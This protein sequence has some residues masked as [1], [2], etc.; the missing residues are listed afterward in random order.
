MFGFGGTQWAAQA[1][2]V[3]MKINK[4]VKQK[5]FF[6]FVNESSV[7]LN[8]T[9]FAF[10]PFRPN[11]DSVRQ[12]VNRYVTTTKRSIP[13]SWMQANPTSS[14]RSQNMDRR[15]FPITTRKPSEATTINS[16]WNEWSPLKPTNLGENE[17]DKHSA[18]AHDGAHFHGSNDIIRQ[19]TTT[20]PDMAPWM[21]EILNEY[22]S[23]TTPRSYANVVDEM[24]SWM[25]DVLNE[26]STTTTRKNIRFDNNNPNSIIFG[27]RGTNGNTSG[28]VSK[29]NGDLHMPKQNRYTTWIMRIEAKMCLIDLFITVCKYIVVFVK[30]PKKCHCHSLVTILTIR[31]FV[32]ES[33]V[34]FLP[35]SDDNESTTINRRPSEHNSVDPL[36]NRSGRGRK[37][38][39]GNSIGLLA[40]PN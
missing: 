19:A 38:E 16:F 22:T 18:H 12:V 3:E 23:T 15:F 28:G 11:T 26:Y 27:G 34:F 40:I 21:V 9:S 31:K 6:V 7:I 33:T 37:A 25:R 13:S 35:I 5:F 20:T 2:F 29:H 36:P 10:N 30:C 4:S 24:P 14:V 8:F 32:T 17:I 39:A 1:K